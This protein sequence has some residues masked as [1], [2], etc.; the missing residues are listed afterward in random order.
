MILFANLWEQ[1]KY[2]QNNLQIPQ[3]K[4]VTQIKIKKHNV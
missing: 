1:I 4:I 3:A 2:Q